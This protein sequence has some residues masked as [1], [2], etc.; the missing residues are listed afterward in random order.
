MPEAS[1]GIETL[2]ESS[3]RP[4]TAF[5]EFVDPARPLHALLH[6]PRVS[7]GRV[8]GV[9]FPQDCFGGADQRLRVVIA[10]R[11]DVPGVIEAGEVCIKNGCYVL[12]K[13]LR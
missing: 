9:R 12:H 6:P 5:I 10:E 7:V 2:E 11:H 4:L 1:I 13:R 3:E 8:S